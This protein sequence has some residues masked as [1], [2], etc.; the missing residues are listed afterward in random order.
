MNQSTPVGLLM[1]TYKDELNNIISN[2]QPNN[3]E[4]LEYSINYITGLDN[5]V[6]PISENIKEEFD[7]LIN[8]MTHIQQ[9]LSSYRDNYKR[10]GSGAMVKYADDLKAALTKQGQTIVYS[11]SDNPPV[12]KDHFGKAT[13]HL[14]RNIN[15]SLTYKIKYLMLTHNTKVPDEINFINCTK[16]EIEQKVQELNN[17]SNETSNL[18]QHIVN[19]G[20]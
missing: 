12:S 15:S 8:Q 13:E 3:N 2:N 20:N 5:E 14:F 4:P 9:W 6:K 7:K 16:A 17:Q 11:S 1:K 10:H 19:C 18:V